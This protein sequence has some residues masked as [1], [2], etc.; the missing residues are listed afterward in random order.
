MFEN[1]LLRKIF[2]PKIDEVTGEWEKLLNENL[3]DLYYSP[4]FF[5]LS[6]ARR[7]KL[8]RHVA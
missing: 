4:N 7:M 1:R 6:K 3:D 2:G 5:R 8:P